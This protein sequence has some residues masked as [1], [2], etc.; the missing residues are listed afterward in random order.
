MLGWN[1]FFKN[2]NGLLIYGNLT[3]LN[4]KLKGLIIKKNQ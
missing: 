1:F 4:S 2:V 3:A